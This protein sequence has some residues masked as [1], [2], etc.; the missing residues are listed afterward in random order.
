LENNIIIASIIGVMLLIAGTAIRIF[1]NQPVIQ[2][3]LG[4]I[5]FIIMGVIISD[6]KRGLILCFVLSLV[7]GFI[8]NA[9]IQGPNMSDPNVLVV[10]PVL[11]LT[12]SIIAAGLGAVGGFVGKKFFKTKEFF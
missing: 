6:V 10:L 11:L 8:T 1:T 5:T 12:D 3:I 7:V 9:I 4:L 2:F